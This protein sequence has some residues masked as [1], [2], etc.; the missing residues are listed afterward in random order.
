MREAIPQ[1]LL[2]LIPEIDFDAGYRYFVGNMDNYLNALMSTLKSV[3]SKLPIL[4]HMRVTDEYEGLRT[5][6]QTLRRIFCNIGAHALGEAS[7][8][9]EVVLLNGDTGQIREELTGYLAGLK[10]L[11][12]HL[13]LLFQNINVKSYAQ[14]E[15]GSASFLNYDFTKTKESIRLSADI[16]GRRII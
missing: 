15:A 13:E 3:K 9:V 2:N 4:E 7:Y 16:I 14:K 10:T 1:E 6:A 11:S 12:G 5:I 8:N